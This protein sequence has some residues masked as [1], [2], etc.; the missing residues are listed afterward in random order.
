MELIYGLVTGIVFGFL[1]Q[2]ARVLRYDKQLGAL[3]LQDLTIVKF[4]LSHIIVAMAG[5]YLLNDLGLVKLSIKAAE[6]G[7]NIL[8]G[9][10]FGL[11]WGLLGYCPGT[12]LGAVGEGRFDALWGIA[13][14]LAGA[15][16]F[17]H[18]YDALK[19]T[20]YTWGDLGKLTLPGLFGVNHWVAIALLGA[21]Y[22]LILRY[23][24]RTG[25]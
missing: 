2:K 5:I 18:T 12:S 8:G 14:M 10:L 4:M 20:V 24:E 15:G 1:T 19:A 3:R 16:L 25:L 23:I 17:A 7:P 22:V 13:G 6:L 11:G 21:A 9:L